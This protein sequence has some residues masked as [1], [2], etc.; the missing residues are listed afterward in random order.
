MLR[1]SVFPLNQL[2]F[3]PR[4]SNVFCMRYILMLILSL[5]K[6]YY[7]DCVIVLFNNAVFRWKLSSTAWKFFSNCLNL[8][9]C[10][11]Q[12]WPK[13]ILKP[14]TWGVSQVLI[15]KNYAKNHFNRSIFTGWTKYILTFSPPNILRTSNS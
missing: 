4:F 14:K 3:S 6:I 11:M 1:L 13:L 12:L 9:S 2:Y 10:F 5:I 8:S 7:A 15:Y